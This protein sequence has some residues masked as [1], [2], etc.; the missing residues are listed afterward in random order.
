MIKKI[1]IKPQIEVTCKNIRVRIIKAP[2]VNTEELKW[3]VC[4]RANALVL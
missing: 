3:I 2:L 4:S 1:K